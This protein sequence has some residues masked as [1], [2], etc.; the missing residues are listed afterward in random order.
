MAQVYTEADAPLTPLQDRTIAIIGYGSQGRAQAQNLRDSG[1][2]VLIGARQGLSWERAQ[3]DGFPVAPVAEAV[4]RADVLML[5]VSDE[6]QPRLYAEQIAPH[7]RTGHA[8]GFAHGFNI[9]FGQ[10]TPPEDIDVFMVSPKAVGPQLRRLFLQGHG[11]PCL[12]AV[13]QN[14]TGE[15]KGIALAYARALGGTRAGVYETT[16]REECECDLFGEQAVLCGGVPALIRAAFETLVEAGY[17]PEVAYFECLHEL[18]LITDLI[19]ESGIRGMEFA[20]SDTAHYGAL[21]RGARIVDTHT[22]ETL[23][24]ILHEIQTGAFAREWILENLAGRPVFHALE[25]A[26]AQHPI[27]QVGEA[28]RA[29]MA[30]QGKSTE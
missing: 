27:E 24:Q 11:A 6:Q 19:Y 4:A 1:L 26:S 13:H 20:I 9:H 23:R 29:R 2:Q 22:R 7:L 30:F 17:T 10:I 8:L 15:A 3:A 12:I 14:Y 28:V 18:K 21:T 25:Q 16:F 5:L